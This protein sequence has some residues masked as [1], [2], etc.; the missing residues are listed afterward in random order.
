VI[1]FTGLVS[2]TSGGAP[3]RVEVRVR[4]GP[5]LP[6]WTGLAAG[7]GLPSHNQLFVPVSARRRGSAPNEAKVRPERRGFVP[8]PYIRCRRHHSGSPG[9]EEG[10]ELL[11][12]PRAGAPR[13]H[14]SHIF[15]AR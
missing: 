6:H 11:D 2:N 5:G 8:R 13:A 4:L 10:L 7:R 15:Y 1:A 12:R 9:E 3:A 14:T